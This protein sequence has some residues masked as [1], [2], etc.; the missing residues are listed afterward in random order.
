[1]Y[2]NTPKSNFKKRAKIDLKVPLQRG[3]KMNL[4]LFLGTF[5]KSSPKSESEKS[6]KICR[7]TETEIEPEKKKVFTYL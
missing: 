6:A 1:M 3:V 5:Q 7:K 4:T 2:R